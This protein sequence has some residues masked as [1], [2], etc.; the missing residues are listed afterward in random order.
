M[1]SWL[2]A[3][4]GAAGAPT[5]AQYL[6]TALNGSLSAERLLV[7]T[8]GQI[9]GSDG[10]ANGSYTIGLATMP[11][12][13]GSYSSPI[14]LTIDSQGRVSAIAAGT[15]ASSAID[16]S[17]TNFNG[18][19]SSADNTVQKALDTIDDALAGQT[20]TPLAPGVDYTTTPA[21]AS[22]LTMLVDRTGDIKPG[23]AIKWE[24]AGP[25]YR[26]SVV[27]SITA[28]LLT[29][30]GPPLTEGGAVAH[31]WYADG[32]AG[33]VVPLHLNLSGPY[34]EATSATALW[35]IGAIKMPWLN[36]KAHLARF[37]GT[38]SGVSATPPKFNAVVNGALAAS[39]NSNDG[40]A[41]T[42]A[43]TLVWAA[44]LVPANVEIEFG[45][46]VEIKITQTGADPADVDLT[47]CS[48]W[49]LE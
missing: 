36:R 34:A 27:A 30:Y 42:V 1:A 19:L 39:D 8:A 13:A 16:V 17:T 11:G 38:A 18:V 5:N 21:S 12:V 25:V 15:L 33:R 20:W 4:F 48:L 47:F 49:V 46:L 2:D 31:A 29:L 23:D 40:V 7:P 32:T 14:T 45:E 10:G 28:N 6:V 35:D 24:L 22:T 44:T 43:G 37:G 41:I 26:Y 3:L 9:V